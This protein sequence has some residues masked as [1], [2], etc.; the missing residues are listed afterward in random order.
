MAA[1]MGASVKRVEDLS[2]VTG[3]GCFTDDMA[4]P[5]MVHAVFLRS[6]HAHARIM[7]IDGTDAQAMPG[8]IDVLTAAD[9][10]HG[11]RSIPA[12]PRPGADY[13]ALPEHPVLPLKTVHYVGQPVANIVA[14][15]LAQAMDAIEGIAVDYEPLTAIVEPADALQTDQSPLHDDMTSNLA[16]RMQMGQGSMQEA[17]DRSD[18]IVQGRFASP[19]L[20]ALPLE[21]RSILAHYNPDVDELMLWTSTQVPYRIRLHLSETL[22]QPPASIRVIAPDVG[23]GF[24]QKM[25]LWPEYVMACLLAKKLGRPVKW[26]EGRMENFTSYHSRGF[27]AEVEAAVTDAGVIQGMRFDMIAD[28]GAYMMAFSATPPVN[29]TKRVAGPYDIAIMEIE[30][31]GVIT[32]KPPTGPYRGAGGPEGAFFMES[33]IDVIARE[34][35]LDPA[36]VRQRN[37]VPAAALPYVTATDQHYDSGDFAAALDRALDLADYDQWRQVQRNRT[38]HEPLLGIGIATVT[39]ASGGVG[40]SR[41]SHARIHVL[42]SGDVEVVTDIS[43]HGQG[44]ETAFAQIAAD[45]L[46]LSPERVQVLHSDTALLPDGQGTYASRGMTVGGS[47]VYVALQEA[48]LALAQLASRILECEPDNIVFESGT[49]YNSHY[50]HQPIPFSQMV[51]LAHQTN[52]EAVPSETPLSFPMS[53][54]LPET[55]YAFAAH[56]VVVEIDRETGNLT[57]LRY[58]A[59]HDPGPV[60]NPTFVQGQI[61]GGIAQGIG[62]ALT[63][64]MVYSEHGQPLNSSL[65]DYAAPR[66][67]FCPDII[68]ETIETPST[69]NPM[70]IKGIGELPTVAAPAAMANAVFDAIAIAGGNRPD[71]PL[72]SEK[73]WRALHPSTPTP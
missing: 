13:I 17:R 5:D 57:C 3:Q 58:V 49:A 7:S 51:A 65:M 43:P 66:S 27:T 14:E 32:N 9:L 18:R 38:P 6:P 50:P 60:I 53:Y 8:V 24:G 52:T 61:H 68:V 64:Q 67:G 37:L 19:R 1:Y 4:M 55:P 33:M 63:E 46:G 56:V 16:M 25:E 34:L 69:T 44:T 62:Q 15:Q 20:S 29:A 72:T 47:A 10:S 26:T 54:S 36:V 23:G 59:V 73:I 30:C 35:A 39:K 42:A 31:L 40:Q 12:V 22:K 11:V 28:L 48:R 41:T 2:L 70:R 45:V 21:T 71:T